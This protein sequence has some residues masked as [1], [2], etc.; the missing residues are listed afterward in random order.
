[1]KI[2][3]KTEDI[4]S[5]ECKKFIYIFS[6]KFRA[7][8]NKIL[9]DQMNICPVCIRENIKYFYTNDYNSCY[10]K[11]LDGK[12]IKIN[13][14]IESLQSYVITEYIS[15]ALMN[16]CT[17]LHII[18]NK[19]LYKNQG[20]TIFFETITINFYE[21]ILRFLQVFCHLNIFSV[22][23]ESTLIRCQFIDE[24]FSIRV[25]FFPTD[26]KPLI[27]F[28]FINP[29]SIKDIN[30]YNENILD[31]IMQNEPLIIIGG[32]T[33][34]GKT[35]LSY[36][37]LNRY[38]RLNPDKMIISAEDPVEYNISGMIQRS[39]QSNEYDKIVKSI[40]RHRPDL[41]FVGEIR[42]RES[43]IV[44]MRALLSGHKVMCTIHI[45]SIINNED[46]ILDILKRIFDRM[47]DLGIKQIYLENYIKSIILM[48][49]DYKYFILQK[50][51]L[52]F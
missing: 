5:L 17:D 14:P 31:D 47:K 2:I 30:L 8:Y 40:L 9:M 33:G 36:K 24:V 25:S 29:N 52:F 21:E 42:D 23:D 48:Q 35:T 49:R 18:S 37:M 3:T 11:E 6:E 10:E 44:C 32:P 27:S 46:N 13:I 22:N 50:N 41:I 51:K 20:K 7:K 26:D 45:Q 39:I 38:I 43:A 19:I 1:M 15:K 16:N 34:M 4:S 28:R 12:F